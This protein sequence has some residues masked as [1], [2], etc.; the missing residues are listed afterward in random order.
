MISDSY[1]DRVQ[2]LQISL[3][4]SASSPAQ[5][6]RAHLE[7]TEHG[8]PPAMR[9][10]SRPSTLAERVAIAAEWLAATGQLDLLK[11]LSIW[12]PLK[13][14]VFTRRKSLVLKRGEAQ[15]ADI[16][17][18]IEPL[19]TLNDATRL[20]IRKQF[21]IG[22]HSQVNKKIK[23][24]V[25]TQLGTAMLI[26][27]DVDDALNLC[28]RATG[29]SERPSRTTAYD[30]LK[31]LTK[32]EKKTLRGSQRAPKPHA[33]AELLQR[34]AAT[35]NGHSGKKIATT[36][37][38]KPSSKTYVAAFRATRLKLQSLDSEVLMFGVAETGVYG[39]PHLHLSIVTSLSTEQVTAA[40][41]SMPQ[42]K[43]RVRRGGRPPVRSK[44]INKF[45]GW[46]DYSAKD[47]GNGAEI[48]AMQRVKSAGNL[49]GI[50]VQKLDMI[51]AKTTKPITASSPVYAGPAGAHLSTPKK[52]GFSIDNVNNRSKQVGTAV[53]IQLIT[54]AIMLPSKKIFRP[55]YSRT[56]RIK[57][58]PV[59]GLTSAQ[60]SYRFEDGDVLLRADE[61]AVYIRERTGPIERNINNFL[62]DNN[63]SCKDARNN[64]SYFGKI[65]SDVY[66]GS[67]YYSPQTLDRVV[68]YL[69][70]DQR[71]RDV[72]RDRESTA[73]DVA[74]QIASIHALS[75]YD[76]EQDLLLRELIDEEV[77]AA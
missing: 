40:L 18:T 34:Y 53:T 75:D 47:L 26:H 23:D 43:Q 67:S 49:A 4:N 38:L 36:M 16:R 45:K 19:S 15:L 60:P 13:H 30:S 71:R 76:M 55:E 31:H 66:K 48:F 11:K 7:L 6:D 72:R 39:S 17:K 58:H 52:G 41:Q 73:K 35:V 46:I 21:E 25:S 59:L 9:N 50:G 3:G 10:S 69:E 64:T 27:G 28:M 44:P 54:G 24:K 33:K 74:N 56:T 42:A 14:A 61:A 5:I 63:R 29:R 2:A 70:E 77:A 51:S 37:H 65:P 12:H 20:P 1:I 68:E 22:L 8:I 62:K 32:T 57:D